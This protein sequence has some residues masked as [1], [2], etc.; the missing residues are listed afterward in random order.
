MMAI[1]THYFR[2]VRFN[3]DHIDLIL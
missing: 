3:D 2:Y 1:L